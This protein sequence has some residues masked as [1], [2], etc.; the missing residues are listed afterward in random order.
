MF[1]DSNYPNTLSDN[2]ERLEL[3]YDDCAEIKAKLLSDH[4]IPVFS[5][6]PIKEL[7]E[8]SEEIIEKL[9]G[10]LNGE[11]PLFALTDQRSG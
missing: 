2:K 8:S 4:H 5:P 7:V 10:I 11:L 9:E 3:E 1:T 6:R